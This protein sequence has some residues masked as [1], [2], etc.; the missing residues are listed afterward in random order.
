MLAHPQCYPRIYIKIK[1]A[2][3]AAHFLLGYFPETS[4]IYKVQ[5]I[6]T[7]YYY[8]SFTQSCGTSLQGIFEKAESIAEIKP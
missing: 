5:R 6:I 1:L 4:H 2:A 3:T 8:I 7:I